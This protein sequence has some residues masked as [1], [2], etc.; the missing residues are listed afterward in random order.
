MGAR[1]NLFGLRKDGTEF[2]VEVGLHP[3]ATCEGP[4]VLSVVVDISERQRLDRLKDEFV[5]TVSHELRT[6][7]TSISGS[8]GLLVG[9]A[10]GSL[11]QPAAR[12]LAIAQSNSDRLVRLVNDILDIE[13]MESGRTAFKFESVEVRTL[14]E[15]AIE[16]NRGFAELHGVRVRLAPA[17]IAGE[18]HTDSDRLFQVVTNLLSNAIKFSARDSDVDVMVARRDDVLRIS[19][20]DHGSGIP[21]G[22]KPHVF[23]KFAQ[24]DATDARSKGGTGLGLSIVKEIVARLGGTVGFDDA[25]GGGTVFHVDLA[26]R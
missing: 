21:A 1:R 2:P 3:M 5:A 6:P 11:P 12:L 20:R 17:S 9:G 14:I 13:R 15:Q 23:D 19:V 18:V 4:L 10:A 22:F 24:A 25:R 26:G 7:L 16:S 8:L